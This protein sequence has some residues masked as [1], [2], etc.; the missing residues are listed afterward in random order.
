MNDFVVVVLGGDMNTYG[1]ARAFTSK[2]KRKTIVLGKHQL[3]PT[4]HS[5]LI[6]LSLIHI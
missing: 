6:E 3:Y 5:K 2:Y 4:S 1:V